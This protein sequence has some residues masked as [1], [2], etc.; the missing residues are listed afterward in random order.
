LPVRAHLA[1]LRDG[2]YLYYTDDLY[3]D[4]PPDQRY[5]LDGRPTHNLAVALRSGEKMTG[6]NS[7]DNFVTRRPIVPEQAPLLLALANQVDTA[8][9]GRLW[10]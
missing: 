1:A 4:T 3:R 9:G 10:R 5:L 8:V 2:A 7:V 6:L